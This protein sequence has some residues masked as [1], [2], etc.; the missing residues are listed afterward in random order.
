MIKCAVWKKTISRRRTDKDKTFD[1]QIEDV[2][3]WNNND[4]FNLS[5][6]KILCSTKTNK[7]K[8]PMFDSLIFTHLVNC[9]TIVVFFKKKI[10]KPKLKLN[11]MLSLVFVNAQTLAPSIEIVRI[12][13][14]SITDVSQCKQKCESTTT[15]NLSIVNRKSHGFVHFGCDYNVFLSLSRHD[16]NSSS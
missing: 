2:C 11:L 1:I 13:M 6:R 3:V 5:T 4:I 10:R 12:D 7:S 16:L 14:Q 8:E 9:V 15:T